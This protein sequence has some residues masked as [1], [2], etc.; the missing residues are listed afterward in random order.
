MLALLRPE[1]R[2]YHKLRD[3]DPCPILI[4]AA[5]F[6]LL[7]CAACGAIHSVDA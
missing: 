5:S 7:E 3:P 6:P 2:S 4:L 1:G